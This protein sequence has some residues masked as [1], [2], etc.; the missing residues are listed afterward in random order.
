MTQAQ[1]ITEIRQ[2]F[3]KVQRID[4][5]GETYK[6]VCNLLDRADDNALK[7]AYEAKIPFVSSLALNRMVRRGLV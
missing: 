1:M 6:R 3:A 7:A 2:A 4:P 5:C